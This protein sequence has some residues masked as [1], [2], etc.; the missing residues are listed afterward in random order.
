MPLKS[1]DY[2][3]TPALECLIFLGPNE[4]MPTTDLTVKTAWLLSMVGFLRPSDLARVDLDQYIISN[5]NVLQMIV[6]AP[7]E[8]RGGSRITKAITI[9][10]HS[11]ESSFA[12]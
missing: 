6:V 7:K 5:D 8:K 4:S 10:P 11:S 9:H 1:F 3:I 12:Q 2:D